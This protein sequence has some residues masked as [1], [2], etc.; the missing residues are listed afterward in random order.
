[1]SDTKKAYEVKNVSDYSKDR[2]NE[3]DKSYN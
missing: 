1:M 2:S 3:K